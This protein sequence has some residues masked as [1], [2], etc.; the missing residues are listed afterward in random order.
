[1]SDIKRLHTSDTDSMIGGV[2]GGLA[3]YFGVDSTLVRILFV[4]FA[5]AG[6]PGVLVYL[7]LWFVLPDED[8]LHEQAALREAGKRKNDDPSFEI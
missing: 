1:M 6:G 3:E 2:C 8:D 4:I 5:F 7:V